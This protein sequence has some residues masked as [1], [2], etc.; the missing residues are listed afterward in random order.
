LHI[1]A[2]SPLRLWGAEKWQALATHFA[3]RG[4]HIVW[5]AGPGEAALV[6][7]IK[8]LPP[9][10]VTAARDTVFAGTLDLAQLWKLVAGAR[11]LVAL[12]SGVA[13]LAKLTLTPTVCLYGPGS[14]LLFGTGSFWRD[15]PFRAVTIA[16]YPCRDQ[17]TLFKRDVEWVRRCQR[18]PGPRLTATECPAPG[19]MM[20]I[21][22]AMVTRAADSLLAEKILVADAKK[23]GRS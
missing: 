18:K 7:A 19:C 17:T 5:S 6:D 1:G 13:H 4:L 12:D 21:D 20:A 11:I 23:G 2:G 15:A 22:I 16:D 9:D 8:R 14:A 3:S 10:R